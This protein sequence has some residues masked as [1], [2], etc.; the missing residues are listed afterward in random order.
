MYKISNK[1]IKNIR[2]MFSNPWSNIKYYVVV[3][4]MTGFNL[5]K[6]SSVGC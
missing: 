5:H 4:S 2:I 1:C 3:N 6:P